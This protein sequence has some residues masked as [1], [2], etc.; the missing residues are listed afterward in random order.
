MVDISTNLLRVKSLIDVAAKKADRDPSSITLVAVS[1]SKS[2]ELTCEAA[3]KGQLDIGENY[4]QEFLEKAPLLSSLNI[5]WHFLGYLQ[6]RKVREIIGKVELIHSLDS[7]PLA[8]EMEQ[9]ASVKSI[10]QKCLVEV[11][12]GEEKTKKGVKPGEVAPL[13]KDLSAL[14]HL[15]IVGLMAIPP[16]LW[17]AEESR[18]YF[19][20]LRELRD[21]MNAK[22]EYR[23]PLAHLSMGMSNDF[24]IAIAE[25]ATL[26]RVGTAIF[27]E[28][29]K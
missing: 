26:V 2:V 29:E 18:P 17:N 11:N 15:S 24:Q 14:K 21:E 1:K 12:L 5:R 20:A 16:G 7:Y 27:G 3:Q 8:W 10:V 28:R 4:V 13:L 23:V 19:K 25:G 9:Q 6:R 22:K